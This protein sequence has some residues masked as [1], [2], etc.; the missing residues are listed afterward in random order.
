MR[1]K[2]STTTYPLKAFDDQAS[3][4]ACGT[5][6]AVR[7]LTA[8]SSGSPSRAFRRIAE[9]KRGLF[10]RTQYQN[11]LGAAPAQ[12]DELAGPDIEDAGLHAAQTSLYDLR[13]HMSDCHSGCRSASLCRR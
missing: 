9:R 11:T 5:I 10:P 12:V 6:R 13:Q 1:A 3:R 7:R 2:A 8:A 4:L